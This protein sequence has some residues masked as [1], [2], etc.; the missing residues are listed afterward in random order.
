MEKKRI[1]FTDYQK[2][3][4]ENSFKKFNPNNDGK[5]A[6]ESVS[7]LL[8]SLENAHK[9]NGCKI[10]SRGPFAFP[11]GQQECDF[12]SF[13]KVIE[14]ALSDPIKFEKALEQSFR[15]MDLQGNGEINTDDLMKISEIL[16]ENITSEEE[17]LRILQRAEVNPGENKMNQESLKTFLK[18]DLDRNY[19]P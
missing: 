9:P 4:L 17:A 14:D 2:A 12:D 13:I 15:L 19:S 8:K 1:T 11:N 5:I 7:Q 16:N 6:I 3:E 18:N 10:S